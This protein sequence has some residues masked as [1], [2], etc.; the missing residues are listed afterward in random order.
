MTPELQ[1]RIDIDDFISRNVRDGE[2]LEDVID[3]L[4]RIVKDKSNEWFEK[5]PV[6]SN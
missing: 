1:L 3:T 5:N 6:P 4:E 2:L